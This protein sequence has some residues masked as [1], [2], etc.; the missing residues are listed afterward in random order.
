MIKK[1]FIL[2][3]FLPLLT[4]GSVGYGSTFVIPL[5][6]NFCENGGEYVKVGFST[7]WEFNNDEFD[8]QRSLDPNF[9]SATFIGSSVNG[10]GT[11]GSNTYFIYDYGPFNPGEVWYYRVRA[12]SNSINYTY[13]N[14][15]SY[16]TP[17]APSAPDWKYQVTTNVLISSTSSNP[18]AYTWH[19]EQSLMQGCGISLLPTELVEIYLQQTY[20]KINFDVAP[21]NGFVNLDVNVDNG[22]W[23]NL[24]NGSTVTNYLWNNL[25]SLNS[26]IG[27]HNL[28]VRFT[29]PG[30]T[31]YYREY[32]VFVCAAS[33]ELHK[34]DNCDVLRLYSDPANLNAIP[35][36]VS[37]GYDSQNA[38]TPEF[39]RYAGDA[40]FSC[41][42]KKGFKIYV[43]NYKYNTQDLRNNAAI[44]SSAVRYI[45]SINNNQPLIVGGI[46]M[47]GVI[48]RYALA[49]AENDG[50]PLPAY[51]FVSMDGPHQ[52]AIISKALQDF[53][54]DKQHNMSGANFLLNGINNPACRQ[55]LINSTYE[56]GLAAGLNYNTANPAHTQFYNELN[57][58]N[59]DGYPHLT[60]NIGVS[61]STPSGHNILGQTWLR[62]DAV[63]NFY[64]FNAETFDIEAEENQAG[65][66]LPV[67]TTNIDPIAQQIHWLVSAVTAAHPANYF[68]VT[69]T[70]YL[71]PTFIPHNSSL[72]IV[73]SAS[74][75][76]VTIST[77]N[78]SY[79]DV[80]PPDI[81]E[82]LVNALLKENVYIQNRTFNANYTAI[83][84]KHLYAG[85][86]VTSTLPIGDVNVDSGADVTFKAGVQV[87]LEPGLN[88]AP[89]AQFAAIIGIAHCDGSTEYQYRI[90]PTSQ[91]S[92]GDIRPGDAN[93]SSLSFKMFPN[94]V[95]S[96]LTIDAQNTALQGV[97]VYNVYGQKVNVPASTSLQELDFS[98]VPAGCY[99]VRIRYDQ[100]V[101]SYQ[102]VKQEN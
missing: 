29:D 23:T 15:G 19:A 3:A 72:D 33:T 45:S 25:G 7:N 26:S 52:G 93:A 9:A 59:S 78:T 48:A 12:L 17:P 55:L 68:D 35:V 41:M 43:L 91:Q 50:T 44:F 66:F 2:F 1:F 98:A 51:K 5:S 100:G 54:W 81:V 69:F 85:N 92:A 10:C 24:Y 14:L 6:L 64:Q 31:V 77:A 75:F 56:N 36:I 46:S 37:E 76:D 65:S 21:V 83:A 58:L 34:S 11:C 13:E 67:S 61:F 97:E 102:I 49:K 18:N 16:T 73:G 62:V 88:I 4:F 20:S 39:Y 89:G 8:F 87:H 94:P 38:T 90:A 99:F 95:S 84:Q 86:N 70:R 80:V 79:H 101:K 96:K 30:S 57:S 32:N 27:A 22:G 40:L 47:G 53:K 63:S 60:E 28:K 74:K 82:P 42:I 71:N